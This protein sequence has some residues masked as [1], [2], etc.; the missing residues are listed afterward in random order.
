MLFRS[1][2][3]VQVGTPEEVYYRPDSEYVAR[4]FGDNNILDGALGEVDGGCRIIRTALGRF[5]FGLDG[6]TSDP[7][8]PAGGSAMLV[9]RP[10]AIRINPTEDALRNRL[11]ARIEEIN[12]V[13]PVSQVLLRAAAP[14]ETLLMVKLASRAGGL[15][16]TVGSEVELGWGAGD[17]QVVQP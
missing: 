13:G 6:T 9:V 12:F 15:P 5:A 4:F 8:M 14:S 3:I 7:T 2:R 10:E 17:C 11:H 16:L 1:G